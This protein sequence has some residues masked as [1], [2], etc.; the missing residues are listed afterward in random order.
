MVSGR[1][2][3]GRPPTANEIEALVARLVA[4]YRGWGLALRPELLK[5]GSRFWTDDAPLFQSGADEA[6][7]AAG[8][9]SQSEWATIRPSGRSLACYFFASGA[10]VAGRSEL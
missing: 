7:R 4:E 2:R 3:T 6:K 1:R 8:R 9:C 5:G 10:G